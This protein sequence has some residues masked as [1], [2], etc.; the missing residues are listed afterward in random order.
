MSAQLAP[1]PA[2]YNGGVK[3]EDTIAAISS[4]TG[5]GAR[6]ILRLSGS[7]ALEIA[8][9]LCPVELQT[10]AGAYLQTLSVRGISVPLH[11]YVFRAPRSYSGEDLVE[12]HL[13]G[14]PPLARL[15]MRTLLA[16][17]A[18]AAEAGEFTARAYFNGRI[19]LERAEGVAA[20]IAAHNQEELAAARQLAG[21]ELSRRLAPMMDNL[22][23]VLALVEVGIDF[24]EEDVTFIG[25]DLLRAR[26][27][28]IGQAIAQ[29]LETSA[30]F[31]RLAH[32]PQIVL[33]G[34]PN[35]GKSTLLNA[36]VGA[37]RSVVSSTAGTTRDLLSAEVAVDRGM[38]H[39]IDAAGID[40]SEPENSDDSPQ[41]AIARQM[42]QQAMHVVASAD[43]VILAHD[44]VDSDDA[45]AL[46][47]RPDL[48]V[49][50]KLDTCSDE[51][52]RDVAHRIGRTGVPTIAVSA[53]SG[54]NLIELR[55]MLSN[56]AFAGSS[57]GSSTLALNSRHLSALDEARAAL[58]R[59]RAA[60]DGGPEIIAM[61]LR[62]AID[63]LGGILGAVTPDDV[64]GRVFAA[65]CIG[66]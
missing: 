49:L 17:G 9:S 27:D 28:D 37:E 38:V 56:L 40:Q 34:R 51:M 30:R 35:A 58:N 63:A 18:R 48:L 64:L 16:H 33:V 8:A 44:L 62:E 5:A 61:E 23:Q 11:V 2:P 36:L 42:R 59:A 39:L 50:T 19:G 24:S 47:R 31:Q 66:K 54:A 65:F 6:M 1:S 13:P 15:V 29:L 21:G 10:P 22:A 60:V 25:G 41:A 7:R 57:T 43:L 53:K 4:S 14:N 26:I 55:G 32:E 46:H 45:L 3:S 12:L 20:T 52:A